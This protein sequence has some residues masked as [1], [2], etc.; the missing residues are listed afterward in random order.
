MIEKEICRLKNTVVGANKEVQDFLESR[1]SST[2]KTAASLA[3]LICRPE[4]SYEEIAEIDKERETFA[5]ELCGKSSLPENVIE[6]VEIEI[7]YEGYII[8]QKR[9]VEQYK[10]MEKKLIPKDI[11]Y[12]NIVSLRLEARQKL[13]LF[14]PVSIG[15]ASRISGVSPADVSVLLVYLEHNKYK[16]K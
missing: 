9:Q 6:Q 5:K 3:D 7:K 15:Q 1:K 8:R 12:D 16:E 11:D 10:K 14:R 2:L 13:K 4:L